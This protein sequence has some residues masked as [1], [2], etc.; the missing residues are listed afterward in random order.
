MP[1]SFPKIVQSRGE[2]MLKKNRGRFI[3]GNPSPKDELKPVWGTDEIRTTSLH[4][5]QPHNDGGDVGQGHL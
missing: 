1:G 5:S 3:T 2:R 4:R